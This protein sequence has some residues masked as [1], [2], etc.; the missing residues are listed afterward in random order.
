MPYYYDLHYLTQLREHIKS[1]LLFCKDQL[2]LNRIWSIYYTKH[3]LALPII[4]SFFELEGT[5]IN[6]EFLYWGC[7]LF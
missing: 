1:T 2:R 6:K 4:E 7:T 3:T 5:S